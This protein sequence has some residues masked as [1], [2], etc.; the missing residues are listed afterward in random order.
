MD[1]STG[2]VSKPGN[3]DIA[4][5]FSSKGDILIEN[6]CL[7]D[8]SVDDAVLINRYAP[9]KNSDKNP[10][11][12]LYYES[13]LEAALAILDKAREAFGDSMDIN[14]FLPDDVK[15]S[16][17]IYTMDQLEELIRRSINQKFN[18]NDFLY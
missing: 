18:Y 11:D 16:H 7:C 9:R 3:D 15:V 1:E 6:E 2:I 8:N 10:S 13:D 17:N 14:P 4:V 12:F 5:R